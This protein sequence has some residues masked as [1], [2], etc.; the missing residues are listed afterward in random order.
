MFFQQPAESP[1]DL[2][3]HVLGFPI[4]IAWGFWVASVIIGFELVRAIEIVFGPDSPGRLPLLMLWAGCLLVSILIHELGH[5]LAY[6]RHGIET[7]IVLYHFGGLAIPQRA[8]PSAASN[9]PRGPISH[10]DD[11]WI[12]FSGPFAQLASALLL[13]M[14]VH[15]AGYRLDAL[16]WLPGPWYRIPGAMDGAAIESPGL[17]ALLVFYLLPSIFWALINLVPVL[18]LDGGQIA[19]SLVLLRGGDMRVALWISVIAAGLTA[20]YGM[21]IGQTFIAIFFLILGVSSFQSLQQSGGGWR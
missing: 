9:R 3:F 10:A 7:S 12:S 17:N 5:A 6:R 13:A 21:S 4:R 16:N 1:Y 8:I 20:A 14:S 2:R 19:K 11:L 15:F 18:P